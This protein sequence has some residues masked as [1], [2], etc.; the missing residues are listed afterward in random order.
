MSKQISTKAIGCLGSIIALALSV[1]FSYFNLHYGWGLEV[2]NWTAY[3][4]FGIIG[5]LFT[6]TVSHIMAN[7]MDD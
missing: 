1:L 3:I 2:K 6:F 5:L 7:L 4:W